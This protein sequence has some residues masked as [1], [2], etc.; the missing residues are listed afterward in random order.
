MP[1]RPHL[2][3]TNTFEPE[4]IVAMS[5]AFEDAC[6]QLQVF[7]GD[8]HGRETVATRI[9]DLARNGVI[10]AAALSNRVVSETQAMRTL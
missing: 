6:T 9:I 7:A 8:A 10:D 2:P 1:I 5:K 4:A 3:E